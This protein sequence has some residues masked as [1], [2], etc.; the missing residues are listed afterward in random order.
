MR[1]SGINGEGELRG[2]PANPGSPGKM[3][4]KTVCVCVCVHYFNPLVLWQYTTRSGL[5]SFVLYM[6]SGAA[7]IVVMCVGWRPSVSGGED[8][9][10]MLRQPHCW[11]QL[12]DFGQSIDMTL[13]PPDTTFTAKVTTQGF[14]CTEMKTNRPWTYQVRVHLWLCDKAWPVEFTNFSV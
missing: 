3:G 13:F 7:L 4:I 12:I 11:L 9:R 14:Q 8:I 1:S 5:W 2:Q 6:L 10:A